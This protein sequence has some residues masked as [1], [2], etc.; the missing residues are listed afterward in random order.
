[1]NSDSASPALCAGYKELI[2]EGRVGIHPLEDDGLYPNNRDLPLLVYQAVL[3]LPPEDPAAAIEALFRENR[4]GGAWRNGVYG[5]HHYHSMAHEVLAVYRGRARLQLGGDQGIALAVEC[6]DVVIIPAGVAHKN[7]GASPDFRV[8]GAYPVGQ[9]PDMNYGQPG[10]RPQA[11]GR[12]AR[13]PLPQAD[14]VFAAGGL[15]IDYWPGPGP[16]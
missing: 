4:W 2:Q 15:C 1:L 12:I 9:R 8:V 6:G 10:E 3:E 16:A 14:P 7:L 13:V 11:D 5:F